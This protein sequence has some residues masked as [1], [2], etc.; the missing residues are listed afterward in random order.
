MSLVGTRQLV[1]TLA[2][3]AASSPTVSTESFIG[4]PP[5]LGGRLSTVRSRQWVRNPKQTT[6]PPTTKGETPEGRVVIP[7]YSYQP[8]AKSSPS[9]RTI[10]VCFWR[11]SPVSGLSST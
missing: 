9:C 10:Q 2:T 5:F 1:R 7:C 6:S 8:D 4:A 11:F 3:I